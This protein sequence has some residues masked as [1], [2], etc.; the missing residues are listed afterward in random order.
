MVATTT[1]AVI[2]LVLTVGVLSFSRDYFS[3]VTRSNTQTV[4]RSIIDD[5]AHSLQFSGTD[6]GSDPT[7]TKAWC[8]GN[9]QYL[10]ATGYE[11]ANVA[12]VDTANHKNK[13][14]LI[15]RVSTGSCD[16]DIT[17]SS[18]SFNPATDKELLAKN[19]RI[20]QFSIVKSGDAYAIHIRVAYGDDD[21]FIS[22]AD[23]SKLTCKSQAGSQ[24]CATSDLTTTVQQRIK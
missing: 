24:F 13:Y 5:V 12:S 16:A 23:M 9:V 22:L 18:F 10:Y 11:V 3:S 1:F 2:L 4:T 15:K 20:S 14:G 6:L 17:T 19:M 8:V 21:M 7:T